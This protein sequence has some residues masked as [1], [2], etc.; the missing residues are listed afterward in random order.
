MA[1]TLVIGLGNPILKDDGVGIQVAQ[2][3]RAAVPPETSVDIRELSV[4]GLTLMESMVGYERVIIIDA[5]MT[6]DS[7]PGTIRR[8]SLDEVGHTL[9]T[10]S[11]HDM[12]LPTALAVGRRMGAALPDDDAIIIIGIEAQEVLTFGESCTEPVAAV[13]PAVAQMVLDILRT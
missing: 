8:L 11:S 4:G 2:V 5:L 9:N 6:P 3:L 13:V 10:A 12:N 1:Q 7:E